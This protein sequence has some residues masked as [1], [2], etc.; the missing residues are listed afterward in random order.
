M[1]QTKMM[2]LAQQLSVSAIKLVWE[3]GVDN[4][5]YI[6]NLPDVSLCIRRLLHGEMVL[7]LINDEGNV[8]ESM[9]DNDYIQ[10]RSLLQRIHD[11]ARRSVFDIDQNIDKAL[12]YLRRV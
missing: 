2:Q 6:V 5:S 10:A 1:Q 9:S 7:D 12:E 8:I 4:D 3:E 11:T